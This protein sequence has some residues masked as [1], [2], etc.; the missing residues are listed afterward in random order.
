MSQADEPAAIADHKITDRA[1][2]ERDCRVAFER[3]AERGWSQHGFQ[4]LSAELV[5]EFPTTVMKVRYQLHDAERVHDEDWPI[6]S[7]DNDLRYANDVG[8][9]LSPEFLIDL[10]LIHLLS[11]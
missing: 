2:Y 8:L 1:A 9:R 7:G 11:G 6:W 10:Q 4:P 3:S 5:G